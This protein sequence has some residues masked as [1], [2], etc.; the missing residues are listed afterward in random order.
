[1]K[2]IRFCKAA[3]PIGV[4]VTILSG[5]VPVLSDESS[6]AL[7]TTKPNSGSVMETNTALTGMLPAEV[8]EESAY[9]ELVRLVKAGVDQ[10]VIRTYVENSLRFFILDADKIIYLT[11]LGV[12]AEIIEAAMERDKQLFQKG[13]LSVTEPAESIETAA[14]PPSVVTTND[15]YDALA[16]YGGWID[17]EG[18]GRCWRPTVVIYNENWRPYSDNGRWVYTDCGWYWMSDYSWGWAAFHYGRWFRHNRYGWCWWPDTVWSPSWVC[19]RY[20]RDYCG[21]APLPPYTSC[22][23]GAGIVYR[24][25]RVNIGFNFGL[26]SNCYTFIATKN[27][28]DPKP[29]RHRIDS[30]DAERI[31]NRTKVFNRM[32]YDA[33]RKSVVNGGIDPNVISTLTRKNIDPVFIRHAGS[34]ATNN[35]RY[36][37]LNGNAKTLVVSRP[38]REPRRKQVS[39]RGGGNSLHTDTQNQR[40]TNRGVTGTD[41]DIPNRETVNRPERM[42]G[43]TTQSPVP[44]ARPQGSTTIQQQPQTHRPVTPQQS[45]TRR[46]ATPQR[47]SQRQSA[48]P[49]VQP[50]GS[51]PSQVKGNSRSGRPQSAS[52]SRSQSSRPTREKVNKRTQSSG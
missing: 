37:Q 31:Y 49:V 28:C 17:V 11:D 14:N 29:W 10:G 24:G 27:F 16:P 47:E 5:I 8:E 22:R 23:P 40:S 15:F 39:A 50:S 30:R 33:R 9:N 7:D 46:P 13:T 25:N 26:N 35:N 52:P 48:P 21:W 45:Q 34:R 6:P 38:D 36:E 4:M 32:D 41:R 2:T 42:S 20:D 44:Q 18:Y 12:P 51:S 3:I 43:G 1:M 19:W